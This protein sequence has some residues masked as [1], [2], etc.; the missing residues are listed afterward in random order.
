MLTSS[1]ICPIC[2][3][4]LLILIYIRHLDISHQ[5]CAISLGW[6]E[7]LPQVRIAHLSYSLNRLCMYCSVSSRACTDHLETRYLHIAIL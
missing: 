3:S 1:A 7:D 6:P 4:I 2:G 5:T